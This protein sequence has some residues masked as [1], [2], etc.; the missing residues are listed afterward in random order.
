MFDIIKLKYFDLALQKWVSKAIVIEDG[1]EK[2]T[3]TGHTADMNP[4]P[5]EVSQF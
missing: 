2:V 4:E 1:K 5:V 3:K